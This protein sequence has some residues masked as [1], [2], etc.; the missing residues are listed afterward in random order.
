MNYVHVC[1]V[2]TNSQETTVNLG[3]AKLG[4]RG[5]GLVVCYPS[6]CVAK[7]K[8]PVTVTVTASTLQKSGDEATNSFCSWKKS[9][10]T[11]GS[12]DQILVFLHDR[13]NQECHL[14][15]GGLRVFCGQYCAI[16]WA[17]WS[18]K[19]AQMVP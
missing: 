6:G 10:C 19:L 3:S 1:P 18:C 2:V 5:L 4:E 14:K 16:M 17:I 8:Y 12:D 13:Q 7:I 11:M 9:Q 15:S